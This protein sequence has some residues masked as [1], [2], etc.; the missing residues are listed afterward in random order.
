MSDD[1]KVQ[2]IMDI[3]TS[4]DEK[5]HELTKAY[6]IL[7]AHA[8]KFSK[9]NIDS[10]IFRQLSRDAKVFRTGVFATGSSVD[11]LKSRLDR[12]NAGRDR[13]FRTDHIE[14]YNKMIKQ[15]EAELKKLQLAE[16]ATGQGGGGSV[17]S[18]MGAVFGGMAGVQLAQKAIDMLKEG[19]TKAFETT[20][21]YE[22]METVLR[23]AFQSNSKAKESVA[24]ITDFASHTPFQ[25]DALTDSFLR[26]VN[27]GFTPTYQQMTKLG[28]LAASQGKDF[29]QLTEALLDAEVGEYRM[30]NQ[31]GVNAV[32]KGS[33]IEFQFKNHK[34]LIDKSAEAI[35][36]YV[37]SLGGMQGV[38]G[39]MANISK[40]L[41]GQ[42]SNLKDSWDLLFKD[43]GDKNHGFF[44]D[45]ISDLHSGVELIKGWVEVPFSDSLY[46]EQSR[47]DSLVDVITD[48]NTSTEE[49]LSLLSD[50][51][52]KYP[53][54]FGNID[55]ETVKNEDLR[56]KL[57]EVNQEYEKRIDLQAKTEIADKANKKEQ[58]SLQDVLRYKEQ[59]ALLKRLK[60]IKDPDKRSL[61]IQEMK[62]N[63]PGFNMF[64]KEGSL[65]DLLFSNKQVDEFVKYYEVKKTEAEKKH[66]AVASEAVSADNEKKSAQ[67]EKDLQAAGKFYETLWNGSTSFEKTLMGDVKLLSEFR[68]LYDKA[69]HTK[70]DAAIARLLEIMN[71]KGKS[72][73]G[74]VSASG[75]AEGTGSA[76]NNSITSGGPRDTQINITIQKLQDKTEI[77]VSSLGEGAQKM[78]DVVVGHLVRAIN[79]MNSKQ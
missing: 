30:L 39:G 41:S 62:D 40:T 7:N 1:G 45:F 8:D 52:Q 65:N 21:K 56:K 58:E 2:Y 19:A 14:K 48:V 13:A 25:V 44:S 47:M 6:D 24:M 75:G 31:F 28:D 38:T 10:P 60:A 67:Q 54:Y 22:K 34:T 27:R 72:K 17:F 78:E 46:E 51:Q 50:L 61:V 11:G 23:T 12:L 36:N 43:I 15:T 37:V 79:S 3:V 57:D 49:R 73:P 76:V 69:L 32:D 70:D 16:E 68:I 63:S 20:A 77:H 42:V 9:L 4:G 55:I 66:N 59:L 74:S 33:K 5:I 35:R 29:E 64:N 18:G 26:L 71:G 53:E